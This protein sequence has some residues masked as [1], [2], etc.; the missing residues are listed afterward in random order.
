MAKGSTERVANM[1]D[2]RIT[3]KYN[4]QQREAARQ[5]IA[6]KGYIEMT[7]ADAHSIDPAIPEIITVV[8][9]DENGKAYTQ[10]ERADKEMKIWGYSWNHVW[11]KIQLT[12]F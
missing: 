10:N 4:R 9:F 11:N 1:K 5:L 7:Q 2:W 12:A 3:N 8:K 6:G